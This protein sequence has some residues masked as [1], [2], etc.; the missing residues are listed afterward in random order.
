M[1]A[2]K[3]E[4][5]LLVAIA[6]GGALSAMLIPI[7]ITGTMRGISSLQLVLRKSVKSLSADRNQADF[8]PF[9]PPDECIQKNVANV[10]IH[11]PAGSLQINRAVR[12][13][14]TAN[15]VQGKLCGEIASALQT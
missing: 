10:T 14:C 7:L 1:A 15:F 3:H 12:Q 8:A 5:F 2:R 6:L 4:L 13:F 9:M 11:I